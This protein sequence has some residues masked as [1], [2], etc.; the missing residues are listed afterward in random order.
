MPV[1]VGATIPLASADFYR[2]TGKLARLLPGG[3]LP[4]AAHKEKLTMCPNL[5]FIVLWS[6]RISTPESRP[7]SLDARL[8]A[9]I[10]DNK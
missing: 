8:P 9:P 3:F 4:L 1:R 7:T 5:P 6:A 2:F 10:I